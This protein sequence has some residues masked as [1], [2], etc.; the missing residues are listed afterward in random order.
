MILSL[1]A[2]SKSGDSGSD[3]GSDTNQ[4]TKAPDNTQN[5][6]NTQK[7]DPTPTDVPAVKIEDTD[8]IKELTG[9]QLVDGK[10]PEKKHI[11]VEV[12]DRDGG[13]P[14]N[15]NMYTDFIKKGMLDKYNVEVEFV[16]VP[17]WTEVEQIN[18]LLAANDAPDICYSYSYATVQAYDD[19]GGILDMQEY[20][21]DE[22]KGLFSNLWNWLGS[23][24]INFHKEPATGKV[25]AIEGKR[26]ETERIVTFVRQDWLDALNL[27]APTTTQEFE[28]MLVAFKNN[29]STLLGANA[30]EM[31]CYAVTEDVGWTA[32]NLIESKRDPNI[33]DK[34][35]YVY[36]FDDRGLT[37]PGTKEAVKILNKWYNMGLLWNDF[38]LYS[39]GDSD[40]LDNKL[41]A[42]YVGAYTQ[43][44][45]MVFRSGEDGINYQLSQLVGPNAKF[46]AIDPFEDSNGTHTKYLYSAVGSDRKIFF[47]ATNTEP[48]A[49][50]LYLDFISD[51]ANVEYLQ[52]GDEGI[53]HTKDANGV[54]TIITPDEAHAGAIPN[55]GK[56]IDLT[57][58]TNGL[59]LASEDL[60][61]KS[62]AYGYANCDPADVVNAINV[63]LHDA[64]FPTSVDL[65]TVDAEVGIGDS[66]TAIQRSTFD[67]A[68]SASE[69]DF[70]SVWESGIADYMAAGGQAIIDERKQKWEDA[71]GSATMLPQ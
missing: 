35:Q 7:A 64:K 71:Y 44:Y 12:Y 57:M 50:M 9:G 43:N 58:T 68:V 26:S 36:G 14:A 56:N 30:N 22:Y 28:D 60:T 33:S 24:G 27:K 18:N 8:E 63:A 34:D 52:I 61:I 25:I 66:L 16:A 62:R 70:D 11:T 5:T 39:S 1:A 51:P 65:G 23:A 54:V 69:A 6:Q 41:K 67:K 48:L 49:C 46:V 21:T 32:S 45:D 59:R 17:R 13:T 29:A 40:V 20:L 47:P 2:C 10:F 15:D 31:I 4:T 37:M 3:T 38:A 42:G 55:S 53:A 19:M